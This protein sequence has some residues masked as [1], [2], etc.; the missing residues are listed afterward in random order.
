MNIS[1]VAAS[2]LPPER[3]RTKQQQDLDSIY[4]LS[5][6]ISTPLKLQK[7]SQPVMRFKVT[8]NLLCW[9]FPFSLQLLICAIV[10]PW[11]LQRLA[12]A[13]TLNIFNL[14]F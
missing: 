9:I 5:I 7:P 10:C 14:R 6:A 1:A 13:L 2:L 3:K 11:Q 12:R 8:G 4:Q